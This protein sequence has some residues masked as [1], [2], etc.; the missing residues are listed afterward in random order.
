VV[1]TQFSAAQTDLSSAIENI[2]LAQG[3]M[4]D[5]GQLGDQLQKLAQ[6]L[7]QFQPS[8]NS[9]MSAANTTTPQI[10]DAVFTETTP[11]AT[12]TMIE[13][14]VLADEAPIT[15]QSW[16]AAFVQ[17]MVAPKAKAQDDKNTVV[18]NVSGPTVTVAAAT[19]TAAPIAPN[20]NTNMGA[21]NV[22]VA[23]AIENS[24]AGLN[25]N[26]SGQNSGNSGQGSDRAPSSPVT[27]LGATP[28]AP[29]NGTTAAQ[30]AN[31]T[32][33]L[34]AASDRPTPH[35]AEQV[36]FNIKTALKD[37]ASKIQINLDPESLGKL[38]IKM[39]VGSDGKATG[40]VITA[41]NKS[42]LDLLQRDA[43][44][45]ENA[46]A[47]AG[48]KAESGSL[49]FNLRGGDGQQD[50]NRASYASYNSVP[51]EEDEL[52]PLAVVSRNYVVNLSD[53]LDIQI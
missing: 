2:K 31:F 11:A 26:L 52:A 13:N 37:G 43:R 44:G 23:N 28:T 15:Q 24:Q 9:A 29:I 3:D 19:Q 16:V 18:A 7:G 8:A 35:V 42:T 5:I 40:I 46:L 50:E 4:I 33:A 20:A 25:S 53:G 45:L 34:N 10:T 38:H 30:T 1:A 47:D 39:D 41:D 32:K 14:A 36:A 17:K 48:I 51:Q 49:S 6:W 22:A 21:N 27:G 12:A